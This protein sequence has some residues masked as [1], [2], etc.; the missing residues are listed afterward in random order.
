MPEILLTPA[1]VDKLLSDH[2]E[3]HHLYP[4]PSKAEPLPEI[5]EDSDD[6]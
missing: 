5:D 4:E 6:E 2:Y 3:T 1:Q